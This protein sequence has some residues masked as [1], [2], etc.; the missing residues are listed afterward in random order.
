MS[1]NIQVLVRIRPLNEKELT[2]KGSLGRTNVVSV[3]PPG[4]NSITVV[5]DAL[6]ENVGIAGG[7]WRRNT[8]RSR[9]VNIQS[10]EMARRKLL[11]QSSGMLDSNVSALDSSI[12]GHASASNKTFDFDTVL[13][14][15]STQADVYEKVKNIIDGCLQ[16]YNGTVKFLISCFVLVYLKIYLLIVSF[17]VSNQFF[18]H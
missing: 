4:G 10:K 17:C 18:K 9:D 2:S 15:S 6:I 8:E 3:I 11:D 1:S 5:N 7:K 14:P 12:V 16:G 13:P